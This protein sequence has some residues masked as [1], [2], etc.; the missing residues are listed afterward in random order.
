M[1]CLVCD[2]T[3]SIDTLKQLFASSPPLL[4]GHCEQN[5]I[6]KRGNVLFE[7]NDWIRFVIDRLNQGDL[8]L[9]HLF[10]KNLKAALQKKKALVSQ[11]RIVEYSEEIPYPWLE[12]L[13]NETLNLSG[14]R[15]R[16]STE[17]LVVSVIDQA[18]ISN[19]ISIIA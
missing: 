6:S 15:Q 9:I 12:I 11:I 5:F 4:C 13:V 7:N 3:I 18:N 14:N 16:F 2:H 19:Q 1:K 17:L 8:I 10:K